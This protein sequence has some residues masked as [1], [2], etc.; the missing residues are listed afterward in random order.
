M[1]G[2]QCSFP[3]FLVLETDAFKPGNLPWDDHRMGRTV[4][5]LHRRTVVAISLA[6]LLLAAIGTSVP[7]AA[8]RNVNFTL[9]G[10]RNAGWG[11]TN[12][13]LRIPGPP[14]EVQV[15]DNVTLNLTSVDMRNHNWFIDYNKNN[16]SDVGEPKSVVCWI[17]RL[18]NFTVANKTGTFPYRSD[19]GGGGATDATTMW[20]NITIRAAGTG[21]PFGLDTAALTIA[22]LVVLVI[23]VV[24]MAALFGRR[25]RPPPVPPPPPEG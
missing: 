12:V 18:W 23:A 20:G 10:S 22:G 6:C 24:A 1:G 5:T 16:V 4:S 17:A 2:Y 19:R 21:T 11:F 14:I 7:S 8:G 25:S 3:S 13:S 9:Y 15:G